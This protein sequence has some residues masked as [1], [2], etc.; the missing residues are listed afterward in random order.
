MIP[1]NHPSV[2]ATAPSGRRLLIKVC[3]M[4]DTDNI[5][6][7]AQL[8]IDLMGFIFWPGTKRCVKMISS[9]AGILPDYS[10]ER[11]R[12][13][14]QSEQSEQKGKCEQTDQ[15]EL[16]ANQHPRAIQRV[17]VFVDEMPQT[18]LTAIYNYQLQYVQL[19]GQESPVMIDNLKR[20]LIPDIAPDIKVIKAIS[21]ASK[22]DVAR[23]K[24]YEGLVDLFLFDTR[25]PMVGGSGRQ[26]DWDVLTAYDGHT[27]FLLSGGIGPDDAE[28]IRQFSH[29]MLAGIDLNSRFETEPGRKDVERLRTFIS[30]VRA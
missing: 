9:K 28:R 21:I 6:E 12:R 27:P 16:T 15:G 17:G 7:V 19:H 3:G 24:D 18:I 1:S 26:F 30:Q 22:D 10:E 8:D 11:F 4:R 2:S 23:Y 25:C 14:N 29:P 5:R 20:T 13:A